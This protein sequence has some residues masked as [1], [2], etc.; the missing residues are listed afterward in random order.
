MLLHKCQD[1][2]NVSQEPQAWPVAEK[3]WSDQEC[4]RYHR[5]LEL[6]DV[7]NSWLP[8][9][10]QVGTTGCNKTVPELRTIWLKKANDNLLSRVYRLQW[11]HLGRP[12][13]C[14]LKM[15]E[16]EVLVP[17]NHFD[18]LEGSTQFISE[19][20]GIVSLAVCNGHEATMAS[21]SVDA[22]TPFQVT[23]GMK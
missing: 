1:C 21:T 10:S 15:G 22:L 23:P 3:A 6:S 4:K 20:L 19:A 9:S 16:Q 18:L 5:E 8:K 13:T 17:S 7:G 14:N 12:G 11:Q 2:R